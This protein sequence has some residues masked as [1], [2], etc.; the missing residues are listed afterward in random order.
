[1]MEAIVIWVLSV[2]LWTDPPPAIKIVYSKEYSTRDECMVEKEKWDKKFV[3]L[4]LTKV[5]VKQ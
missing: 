5:V 2:Q 3:S 4:C 1:M